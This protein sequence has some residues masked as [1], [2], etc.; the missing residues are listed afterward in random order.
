MTYLY[1]VLINNIC[2]LKNSN[3]HIAIYNLNKVN[4]N[5]ERMNTNTHINLQNKNER[6][7][8]I[9]ESA[10]KNVKKDV[11]KRNNPNTII[12]EPVQLSKLKNKVN[13]SS[14]YNID[15]KLMAVFVIIALIISINIKTKE[16][17]K[18]GI[19]SFNF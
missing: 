11:M 17:Q 15:L 1:L 3:N 14:V 18:N 12:Y 7:D 2:T 19:Y 5:D 9:T 8:N 10:V 6:L 4:N 16:K 13:N